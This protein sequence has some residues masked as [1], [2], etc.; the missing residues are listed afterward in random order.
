M[1]CFVRTCRDHNGENVETTVNNVPILIIQRLEDADYVL[2]LNADNYHKNMDW[3]RQ[4]MGPSRISEDG[5]DWRF[6]MQ[7]SQ[8][9]FSKFDREKT[10][11]FA[12]KAAEEAVEQMIKDSAKGAHVLD[13]ALLRR[14]TVE[15]FLQNFFG[16]SLSETG[17]DMEK[18]ARMMEYGS[19][20]AFVPEGETSARYQETLAH[21]PDLRREM[22]KELESFRK[23]KAEPNTL[24]GDLQAA[25]A[26]GRMSFVQEHELV[27]LFAAGTEATAASVGWACYL[28]AKHPEVQ[29]ALRQDVQSLFSAEKGTWGCLSKLGRLNNFVSEVLRLYPPTPVI[30]KLAVEDDVIGDI[31]VSAGQNV[32]ISFVGVQ[33]DKRLRPDP[34]K[35]D[36]EDTA[37]SCPAAG[38]TTSFSIG[39]RVC[40]GKHFALV[41]VAT[42]LAF[43]LSKARFV[44]TS[45][46]E[47]KF[48]WKSQMLHAGGQPV[49]VI[50]IDA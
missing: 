41:E 38:R 36:L 21:L 43:F 26:E 37:T 6:R 39:P 23:E 31:K 47:P 50:P 42:F 33:H 40:G 24:L 48:R 29:D 14:M 25:D 34:W 16:K 3:F 2:R 46:K 12:Q 5:E 10:F 27:M 32:L 45:D 28:L 17:V 18:L 7:L 19:E 9:Y 4:V 22:L 1:Q 30:A 15:V 44:L 13:D 20:Y 11:S 8:P 49:S 35:L